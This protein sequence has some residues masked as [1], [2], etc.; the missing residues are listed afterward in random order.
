M[1]RSRPLPAALCRLLESLA[2]KPN[3]PLLDSCRTR[4]VLVVVALTLIGALLRLWS[5]GRLGLLH[6]DEGIYAAAGLWIFARNGILE[7]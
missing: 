5:I 3:P 2:M 7:P 4:E 6:F 1:K